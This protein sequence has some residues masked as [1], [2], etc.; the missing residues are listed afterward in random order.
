[1]S[2]CTHWITFPYPPQSNFPHEWSCTL[3]R[4]TE[5]WA[6]ESWKARLFSSFRAVAGNAEN[7]P[8]A[9]NLLL[10]SW[11]QLFPANILMEGNI[12]PRER[13]GQISPF[14]F[15]PDKLHN[16]HSVSR[17]PPGLR[18]QFC[19]AVPRRSHE[20]TWKFCSRQRGSALQWP[21]DSSLLKQFLKGWTII[22]RPRYP[23][24]PATCGSS[25]M[26]LPCMSDGA[27]GAFRPL[28]CS[29][30]ITFTS[31]FLRHRQRVTG[32]S[33][34]FVNL[35]LSREKRCSSGLIYSG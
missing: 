4:H 3:N 17:P 5:E 11:C 13:E 6:A 2:P 28:Q 10:R 16:N 33:F 1:M 25:L 14:H 19:A 35:S 26:A 27:P 24:L 21:F 18:F 7:L 15:P 8:F 29:P 32:D 31:Y 22:Q 34:V 30:S 12:P 9:H 20:L 23:S